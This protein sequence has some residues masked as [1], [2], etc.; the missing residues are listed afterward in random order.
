MK[1]LTLSLLAIAQFQSV[2]GQAVTNGTSSAVS[3]PASGGS[4]YTTANGF[5]YNIICPSVQPKRALSTTVKTRQAVTT[6]AQCIASCDIV[7]GCQS[8]AYSPT[9]GACN[10]YYCYVAPPTGVNVWVADKIATPTGPLVGTACPPMVNTAGTGST[11]TTISIVSYLVNNIFCTTV[12]IFEVPMACSCTCCVKV[13]VGSTAAFSITGGI[14]GASSPAGIA[15]G[16]SGSANA[17]STV[18]A[19]ASSK[20]SAT[21]SSTPSGYK[22]ASS[23]SSATLNVFLAI[24]AL[25]GTLLI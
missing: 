3:C 23:A 22:A 8:V 21:A 11:N 16:G 6:F 15:A 18:A 24:S 14:N 9:S 25:A 17:V 20:A 4:R 10:L 2:V 5:A 1:F 7:T 13:P 19:Q 12:N